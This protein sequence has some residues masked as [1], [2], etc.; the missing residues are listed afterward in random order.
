MATDID[1]QVRGY[2][3][4]FV[5]TVEPV[6]ISEIKQRSIGVGEGQVRPIR[7]LA[8]SSPRRGWL[9][10]T[11]AAAAVLL[12][13][14]AGTLLLR[15][16]PSDSTGVAAP[17]IDQF[18]SLS[19]SRV[20]LDEPA[21]GGPSEVSLRS[22]ASDGARLVGVGQIGW[23][24]TGTPSA[25]GPS[26]GAVWTSTDG[27]TWSRVPHDEVVFGSTGVNSVTAGSQGFVAVGT[28]R[29][30]REP[31]TPAVW[32]SRDGLSWTRVPHN[33]AVF[34]IG[35]MSSVTVGGPGF[36]AVGSDGSFETMKVTAAVWTSPDGITWS[37]VPHDDAAFRPRGW[38]SSVVAGGPGLVARGADGQGPDESRV[39]WTSPDGVS[40]SRIPLA[41]AELDDA[42]V[43]SV[44]AGGP[45]LVA[46]G[47]VG[48]DAAVWTSADG[49]IWS[50]V[51]HNDA[52]FGGPA[53]I[54]MNS[55]AQTSTGLVAVGGSRSR[56]G[57]EKAEAWTSPD[58]V[59]W[60][61][62]SHD[63]A[64]FDG[65]PDVEMAKVVASAD[66]LVILG[67]SGSGSDYGPTIWTASFED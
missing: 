54:W 59:T 28:A 23:P 30:G 36:V 41:G 2:T 25:F 64:I 66:R 21:D 43:S 1:T 37:R 14:G 6:A 4:F 5:T 32:T 17:P 35:E 60:S 39:I 40:W 58:G 12:L 45:G 34:G 52:V 27:T 10:V 3:D 11:A 50:R 19:W 56:L 38:M 47:T 31:R 63:E 55:V 53:T 46:V 33:E 20:V 51:T 49:T 42:E 57:E 18:P 16:N 48:D 62:I 29:F 61:R 65:Q 24:D 15:A 44:S 8:T 22:A 9:V 26:I 67:P 13:V 7:P